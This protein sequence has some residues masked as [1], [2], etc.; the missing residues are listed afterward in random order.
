MSEVIPVRVP[1]DVARRIK[2]MVDAGL[3]SNRSSLVRE[4]LRRLVASE[5]SVMQKSGFG[6]AVASLASTMIA[7]SEKSVTD[8]ILFGSVA[9]GQATVESDVDLLVLV[10]NAEGWVVRQRLYDL[11]YPIIPA[12]GVDVSLVVMDRRRFIGMVGEGDTFAVSV[13]KEG[14]QLYGGLLDEYGKSAFEKVC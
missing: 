8:V 4:A 2:D 10:E 1:K 3:Y 5:G 6:R 14:V 12:L 7:W 13:L 11:I 9:R